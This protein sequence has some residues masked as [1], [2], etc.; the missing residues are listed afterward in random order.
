MYDEAPN[1]C[2]LVID[3]EGEVYIGCLLFND[4]AFCRQIAALLQFF[5]GRS[6]RDIG[7]LELAFTL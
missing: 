6:T 1:R 3:F 4:I 2:Y 7:D 5:L